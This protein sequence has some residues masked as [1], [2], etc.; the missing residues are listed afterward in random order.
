MRS[1][2]WFVFLMGLFTLAW[3]GAAAA[4]DA[5]TEPQDLPAAPWYMALFNHTTERLIWVNN[6]GVQAV[7]NRVLPPNSVEGRPT[8]IRISPDGRYGLFLAPNAEGT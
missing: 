4:Q 8:T 7:T 1:V 2:S 3:I 6:E 5:P